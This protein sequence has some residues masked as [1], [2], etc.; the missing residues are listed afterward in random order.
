M[1]NGL[2][3]AEPSGEPSCVISSRCPISLAPFGNRGTCVPD[4]EEIFNKAIPNQRQ[5]GA[6]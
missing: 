5:T 1:Y 2:A 3:E 4:K 6:H